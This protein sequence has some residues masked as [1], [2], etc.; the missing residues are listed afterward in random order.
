ML[1]QEVSALSENVTSKHQAVK[2]AESALK[3]L[4]TAPTTRETIDEAE[5]VLF[6]FCFIKNVAQ[7]YEQVPNLGKTKLEK[8]DCSDML[9]LSEESKG[10]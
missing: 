7:S 9:G 2:Q 1:E 10:A 6:N 5:K 4:Q 3:I 8:N